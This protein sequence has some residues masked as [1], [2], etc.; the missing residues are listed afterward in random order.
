MTSI[1]TQVELDEFGA[2]AQ[3]SC[4]ACAG[5]S[6]REKAA[7]LAADGLLGLL[8]P[9]P[10]GAALDLAFALPV[11]A[12]AGRARLAFPL[13]ETMAAAQILHAFAPQAAEAVAAGERIL[14]AP[15]ESTL[16][17]QH[18][19]EGFR[20]DGAAG[21]VSF[22]QEA[23]VLLAPATLHGAPAL[24]LIDLTATR[25]VVA[26]TSDLDVE[27]PRS[28]LHLRGLT[29]ASNAVTTDRA[30]VDTFMQTRD[31]LVA[32]DLHGAAWGAFGHAVAHLAVREQF[33]K[34]LA[35]LQS[36]RHDLARHRMTLESGERLLRFAASATDE[37]R[38]FAVA[39]AA[40]H[41]SDA[42][43]AIA[44]SALH[45]QGGMGFTWDVPAHLWLR[46]IRASLGAGDAAARRETV[47]GLAFA[48]L[49]AAPSY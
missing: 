37:D 7:R 45:L 1:I 19:N 14:V 27:C 33:G 30:L 17:L 28:N 5:L 44:E 3:R 16:T 36:L 6:L 24:V 4:E 46:R 42:C 22:A 13:A 12:A 47:A 18:A 8:A 9:E 35:T 49:G 40:A 43:P 48:R 2:T 11:V 20:L 29:V 41:A 38:A 21:G 26:Q 15:T 10:Q 32:A 39:M 23:D 34:I 31:L 25:A